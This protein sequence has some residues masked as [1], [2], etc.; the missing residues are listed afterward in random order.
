MTRD[1]EANGTERLGLRERKAFETRRRLLATALDLMAREGPDGV[2]IAILA[3]RSD[4]AVGTFYN[5]F[6][7]REAII[8]TVVDLEIGTM[9]R[10]IDVLIGGID[11]PAVG[12]AAT[13]RHLVRSALVD[14]VWGWLNVRLG[15]ASADIESIFGGRLVRVLAEGKSQGRFIV[16]EPVTV[17]A[18]TV[19]ALLAGMRVYLEAERDPGAAGTEFAENQLRAVGISVEEAARIAARRLAE[20]PVIADQGALSIARIPL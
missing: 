2:T 20:L 16:A 5:Y 10:R 12:Y 6:A 13:L 7:S 18:M 15:A 14:P 9:G 17:A 4:I 3:E 8:D 11:D 1:A 19:G